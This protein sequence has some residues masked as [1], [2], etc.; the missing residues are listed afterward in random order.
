MPNKDYVMIKWCSA[1]C[2]ARSILFGHLDSSKTNEIEVNNSN[3]QQ[4]QCQDISSNSLFA[5]L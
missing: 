5:L 1:L 3:Y 2:N 4:V